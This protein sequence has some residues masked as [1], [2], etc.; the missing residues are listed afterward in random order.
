MNGSSSE[1]IKWD[2]NLAHGIYQ[3]EILQPN[4]EVK[5]IKVIY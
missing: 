1:S 2:Y 4:G 5:I 3:L